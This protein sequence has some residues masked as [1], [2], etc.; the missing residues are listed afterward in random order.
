MA[1][2][3][4]PDLSPRT[5]AGH[6][7]RLE[8]LLDAHVEALAAAGAAPSIWTWFPQDFGTPAAMRRF[9]AQALAWQQAGT[10]QAFVQIDAA[11]GAVVGSTRLAQIDATHRRA[12]IGWTWLTPSAQRSAINTEAK[13]LLLRHAFE[14][15]GLMRVEFKTDSLNEKSRRALK[16][17]GATEEGVFRRHMLTESG[18]VRDSVWFSVVDVE[19]P[20][21][22]A[23]LEQ[24][25][26]RP[27]RDAA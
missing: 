20:A 7:V 6:H 16:R 1:A 2:A 8:P 10:A 27:Y 18:R 13:Y 5:L 24:L 15:L 11:S 9:V 22:R 12:E 23:H 3:A 19:W 17:I 25:L 14:T 26:A 4:P 21:V